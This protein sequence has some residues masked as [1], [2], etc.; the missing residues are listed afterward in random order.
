MKNSSVPV[1]RH[2]VDWLSRML[3]KLR[4]PRLSRTEELQRWMAELEQANTKLARE[5]YERKR[6]EQELRQTE[7]KYRSIFENAVDGIFQTT[8]EGQYLSVNPALASIYGYETPEELMTSLTDIGGQLYVNPTRRDEFICLLHEQNTVTG[9]ESQI[10]RRDGKIVW[11]TETARAV[12]DASGALLYYEGIVE[13]ITE[14]RQAEEALHKAKLAAEEAAN[15]KSEFLANMSHELRTP[16]NGIMGMTELALDTDL[17][18]DQR[19]YL[20]IVQD[21]AITLLDLVS[22]ILDFSKIEVGKLD[23]DPVV[24]S[25]RDNLELAIKALAIRAH[26]QG[27]E[28]AWRIPADIPDTLFGDPGRL[29][30]VVVNLVGNAIKFTHEGEVVVQVSIEWHL[31]D[32]IC[33]HFT[34]TDTGIGIAPEKQ[35]L[36]FDPFTQADGST[37][38]QFGGTGLGLAI[39]SQ[40]VAMM[41]G[42]IWVESEVNKGSTFHFT[43]CFG[44]RTGALP[45]SLVSREGLSGLRVL[46]VDDNAT[47]RRILEEQLTCWG[48]CPVVVESG[49]QALAM[50]AQGATAGSPFSLVLLDA[51]MPNMD[52]FAV[53]ES[54]KDSPTFARATIMMLT[55]EG[56]SQDAARCRA[57]GITAY[58]TKPIRQADLLNAIVNALHG[59]APQSQPAAPVAPRPAKIPQPLHILVVEDNPI[60]QRLA[61]LMLKKWGHSVVVA[62]NGKD[63][64]TMLE[65]DTFALVLMDV[66]M[67]EMDGF[68]AT[69]AIR[70]QEEATGKH[71]PIIALTARAMHG[72][73]E[74]C[75]AAGM[76]TY[77]SKPLQ[78]QQL[79]AAIER[80]CPSVSTNQEEKDRR[81]LG[82]EQEPSEVIFDQE[83]ALAHVEGDH[84]LLKEVVG[85]FLVESP[86][87]LAVIRDSIARGDGEMLQQ[88]AHSVKGAVISFGAHAAREAA[89]KL[90]EIGRTS[91]LTQAEFAC[92]E[93]DR[94]IA[95]LTRALAVYKGAPEV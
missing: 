29:R 9:F 86:E 7:A 26:K 3:A 79:S 70:Q 73:Q 13:D 50:L 85:L 35:K 84:E 57:L 37:T 27:L 89:L 31:E 48:M 72:D 20:S 66:Q 30:Q 33:L 53:A 69:Q 61:V 49:E 64:L 77:L 24:F 91:D 25:L 38:R 16:L 4:Q 90:E 60:N 75:L 87:L 93:L 45:Q 23:L 8:P 41:G 19:E 42:T 71:I 74:R 62:N 11:I 39:S 83:T 36:I 54:I 88:A 17:S 18:S 44:V 80:L 51:Q 2:S 34:V 12:R 47:N 22:D 6:A 94:E 14:R 40:L 78:A 82:E 52:G 76:D 92:A 46:V 43:A 1:I 65:K 63:A 10:Y 68:T 32:E 21:S 67:P 95:H 28:L 58:L 55:S 56:H 59:A 81:G 5:V 15:T